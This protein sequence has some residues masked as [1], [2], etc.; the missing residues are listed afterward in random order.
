MTACAPLRL[1]AE[2]IEDLMT[3]AAVIQDAEV[4]T[5]S[6]HYDLKAR[7]LTLSLNRFCHEAATPHRVPTAIQIGSVIQVKS[8][9]IIP[10]QN[11]PLSLLTLNMIE[12]ETH[13]VLNLIFAG[14]ALPEIRVSIECL[15]LILMDIGKA[16]PVLPNQTTNTVVT[17]G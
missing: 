7:T 9:Q 1:T 17:G 15:D 5:R 2:D 3:I 4:D 14:E 6:I 13:N 16:V 10:D 12:T 8:R 11:D